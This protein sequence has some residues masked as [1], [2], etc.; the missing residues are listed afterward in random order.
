VGARPRRRGARG[1]PRRSRRRP[2]RT[3][4]PARLRGGRALIDSAARDAAGAWRRGLGAAALLLAALAL[5]AGWLAGLP[6]LARL[7]LAL[8]ALVLLPGA[9]LAALVAPAGGGAYGV[10]R[11]L[12][13]GV[14]WNALW[15]LAT[16]SL[17]LRF[18]V[19]LEAAPA[20]TLVLWAVVTGRSL[21]RSRARAWAG[22]EEPAA[23][24]TN[25]AAPLRGLA[26][27]AVLAAAALASLHA[28]RIG[29]PMSY[30]SDSPD[31]VGTIRRMIETGDA[32]PTDAFFKNAGP[33]GADPRKGLWHP[34]VALVAA[35]AGVDPADAW[36]QLSA[37]LAPLFILNLARLGGM[38]AG[39]AGA[40]IFAWVQ[41]LV[42]A[43][44]LKWF[45][46]CKAVFSTFLADQLCLAA[47]IAVLADVARPT[48]SG[49]WT[50][51]GL[52]LGAVACHLY[53]AIQLALA[54]GALCAGLALRERALRGA[55]AR[56]FGT[57]AIAG[58]V[59]LPYLLWRARQS[60]A[61]VNIIHTEPQGLLWIT[62]SLRVVSPGVLWDW[63][64]VLWILFP[65]AWLTLWRQGRHDPAALYALT[66][67][68]AVAL[69]IFN[70]VAVGILEP[71]LGYLLMRMIWMAPVGALIGWLLIRLARGAWGSA[72]SPAP[73]RRGFAALGLAGLAA[74][75]LPTALDAAGT[76][77]H[78]G[79]YAAADRAASP[80]RWREALAW[81]E[82]ELP[83]GQVVLS[84]PATSYGVPM[85][86]RHYVATL[87]DQ[88][89]SP[90]DS[91]ALRRILDARDALDP[92]ADW[93]RTREVLRRYGVTVVVI[94]DDFPAIPFLD[95]WSPSPAWAAAAR[96]RF[97]RETA[98]FERVHERNGF[99]VY[100][101]NDGALDSLRAPPAPRPFVVPF[102]SGRFPIGR[103][104]A[105]DL[106]VVHRLA[107][108]PARAARG[109]T[110]QGVADWRALGRLP[111][112]SYMV[113]VRFEQPLP[114]GFSP[115]A[116]VAKPARKLLEKL[117]R[118]RFRFR[119]D[120]LP[121]SGSYGV[122]LWTPAEVVRDSFRFVVPRDAA[123]GYY[124]AEIRM[125]RSPHYP[126]LRLSDYFFDRDYY[127]G[128]PMGI[129]E[130][131]RDR[132]AL[133]GPPPPLPDAFRESH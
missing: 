20:L 104:F 23:D 81:M 98:A 47:A 67:S 32:F 8:A 49:R 131:A 109:D 133:A 41:L 80:L 45:P 3:R 132:A 56:A 94:N 15:I 51:V 76:L 93:S 113:T 68:L 28:G 38:S 108:V 115:P 128:V 61:P 37:L 123:P 117:R 46:L 60:Y 1:R 102:V 17:G 111:G 77:L 59:A 125:N 27:A 64:G 118:E 55:A 127:S 114:G 110:V 18:T 26:L 36:R 62:D 99:V 112:G 70:P 7:A 66:T 9:A 91:L 11:S 75:V 57:A 12:G 83:A 90:S 34:Q 88:H 65:L 85:L 73:A 52:A 21:L 130:V 86:T 116:M 79:R 87:V 35:L 124:R 78:P 40:A 31:H 106:P 96:A 24:P 43:G 5:R 4:R 30:F 103:R 97:D 53:S 44:S 29:T 6:E 42:V 71:R 95:Y 13:F 126:N 107:L 50:A 74:V 48:R 39:P 82:R 63:M 92:Y 58:L 72:G 25:P 119:D 100:R 89:S 120:H 22:G 129:L 122:D 16:R 84:D 121:T 54:L 33:E 2:G 69:V 19:L 10:V 14:A 101:V 105:D